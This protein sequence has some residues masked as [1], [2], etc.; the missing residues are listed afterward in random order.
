[1]T[2]T[3]HRTISPLPLAV[4]GTGTFAAQGRA[5]GADQDPPDTDWQPL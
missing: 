1:M 2:H 4:E 3:L 5:A